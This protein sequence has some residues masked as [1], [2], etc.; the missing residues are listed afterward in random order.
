MINFNENEAMGVVWDALHNYRDHCD[1]EQWD[2]MCTA[3]AW[4]SEALER[5]QFNID[6][7][8]EICKQAKLDI[9][10]R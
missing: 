10:L 7:L 3:M 4:F 2:E 1:N 9:I 5:G 8:D 6:M